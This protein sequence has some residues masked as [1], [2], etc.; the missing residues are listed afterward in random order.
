MRKLN[1]IIF[2]Y[3]QKKQP[4]RESRFPHFER[5]LK[6]LVLYRSDI[7]ERND[8][9]KAIRQDLLRRQMDTT[10]W[11]FV[12]KKEVNSAILPQSRILGLNDY[13][14]FGKP[15][16]DILNDL[17]KEQYDVLLDLTTQPCLQLRY[18]ALYA[19]ADCKVGLNLGE[20]IH[21]LLISPPD[22]DAEQ[23]APEMGWLYSQFINYLTSIKSND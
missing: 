11:G 19:K 3:L 15:N 2:D 5:P 6:V 7:L 10:M 20:G 16:Q 4:A 12:Q 23:A 1:Q 14:F 9:V 21:D 22:L 13:N 17:A 8:A 18:L